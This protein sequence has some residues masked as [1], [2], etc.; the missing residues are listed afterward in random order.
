MALNACLCGIISLSTLIV[1][2]SFI[3]NYNKPITK[4]RSLQYLFCVGLNLIIATFVSLF[5]WCIILTLQCFTIDTFF[6]NIAF[7]I[8]YIF[9]YYSLILSLFIRLSNTFRDSAIFQVSKT[10]IKRFKFIFIFTFL[11]FIA[12]PL[13]DV[14]IRSTVYWSVVLAFIFIFMIALIL[15][16][17]FSFTSRL[18]K[19]YLLNQQN[20]ALLS[21]IC[22]TIILCAISICITLLS[23]ICIIYRINHTTVDILSNVWITFDIYSNFLCIIL[24]F[25][26]FT[27]TYN[28]LCGCLHYKC[29][30]FLMYILSKTRTKS[31]GLT[32][33]Q[34][35]I[36]LAVVRNNSTLEDTINAT[37][38]TNNAHHERTAHTV[39]P[40]HVC[41]D[42]QG[43]S[44][45]VDIGNINHNKDIPDA[46][47]LA[48]H[49]LSAPTPPRMGAGKL[50]INAAADTMEA[51]ASLMVHPGTPVPGVTQEVSDSDSSTREDLEE[52]AGVAL[53]PSSIHQG[54]ISKQVPNFD[55]D[56][57]DDSVLGNTRGTH[58]K[59]NTLPVPDFESTGFVY[60]D[61]PVFGMENESKYQHPQ[62]QDVDSQFQMDYAVEIKQSIKDFNLEREI[63]MLIKR[64]K[65]SK[66]K[67]KLKP[68]TLSL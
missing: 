61:K 59:H 8:L 64:T 1:L 23:A 17:V 15:I 56:N 52:E 48:Q 3:K 39:T 13:H 49:A 63:A 30:S 11:F 54:T 57:S 40:A 14:H 6:L 41:L 19:I 7:G 25:N 50:C 60:I 43:R 29:Q 32:R 33:P 47:L 12:F 62:L 22:K 65:K 9:Q 18:L 67:E 34:R 4:T 58:T 38:P 68:Q 37:P 35:V 24:S 44:H 45:S 31:T 2:Y 16:I 20:M 66:L 42:H 36:S 28:K 55:I 5:V 26:Y 10:T 53:Q 27:K 51:S 21:I 46:Q